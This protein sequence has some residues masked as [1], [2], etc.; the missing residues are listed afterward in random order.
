MSSRDIMDLTDSLAGGVEDFGIDIKEFD[1]KEGIG[2]KLKR[3][4]S[5]S[6]SGRFRGVQYPFS[7]VAGNWVKAGLT[8]VAVACAF[9]LSCD[10]FGIDNEAIWQ[11]R[12]AVHSAFANAIDFLTK[13][14]T[15]LLN[16]K[17]LTLLIALTL[18]LLLLRRR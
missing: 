13:V 7:D 11:A 3:A 17:L 14:A 5:V 12:V 15:F 2:D 4:V 9:A 16:N 8:F 6:L 10:A 1:R 18:L